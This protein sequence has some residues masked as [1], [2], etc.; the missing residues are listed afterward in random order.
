MLD[1][2]N[3]VHDYCRFYA[4]RAQ[5]CPECRIRG[6]CS[7]RNALNDEG[8]EKDDE[9]R[10][11]RREQTETKNQWNAHGFIFP[12]RSSRNRVIC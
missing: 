11:G 2:G 10:R 5:G 4:R 9:R 6:V 1:G 12:R 7:E 8:D 3:S